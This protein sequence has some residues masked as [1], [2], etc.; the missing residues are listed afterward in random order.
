[1]IINRIADVAAPNARDITGP[2]K[3]IVIHRTSLAV[4][5]PRNPEPIADEELDAA[6]MAAAFCRGLMAPYTGGAFPYHL[7][8]RRNGTVEQCLPLDVA[9][10][11]AVNYNRCSI[12]I[13]YVGEHDCTA[14]QYRALIRACVSLVLYTRGALIVGHSQLPGA[15]HDPDKVCPHEKF[16]IANL[17]K[18]V[19]DRL[20]HDWRSMP[21]QHID[22]AVNAEGYQTTTMVKK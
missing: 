9:G 4:Q 17:V 2:A 16:S 10:A 12:G 8:V 18:D 11:H 20:P 5:E 6:K 1:M 3:Y 13:A 22:V 19:Q 7:I 21:R 15:S 14:G